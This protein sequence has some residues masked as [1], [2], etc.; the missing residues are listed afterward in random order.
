[1]TGDITRN[2]HW[3]NQ[4]RPGLKYLPE[5]DIINIC[6]SRRKGVFPIEEATRAEFWRLPAYSSIFPLVEL[7]LKLTIH[8]KGCTFTAMQDYKVS[9]HGLSIISG[10]GSILKKKNSS[11][12]DSSSVIQSYTKFFLEADWEEN[13]IA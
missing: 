13:L 11:L 6:E 12:T 1:M 7:T 10:Q 5:I 3:G 2:L 9:P 4:F 8:T